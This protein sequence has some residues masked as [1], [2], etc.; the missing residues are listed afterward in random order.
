ME[1]FDLSTLK[2]EEKNI[3]TFNFDNFV[4]SKS[5][6]NAFV[7]CPKSFEYQYVKKE[8]ALPNK[9]MIKGSKIHSYLEQVNSNKICLEQIPP[10]YKIHILNY[11]DFLK[12][13]NLKLPVYSEQKYYTEFEGLK[14]SGIVDA[15]FVQDGKAIIVDYKTGKE[16]TSIM[17]YRFELQ[18]YSYLIE[19]NLKLDVVKYGILFTGNKLFLYENNDKSYID[20]VGQIQKVKKMVQ[21]KE[22]RQRNFDT[23]C[24]LCSFKKYC[25]NSNRNFDTV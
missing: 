5:S 12:V 20:I 19:K 3:Q 9:Y 6:M 17:D 13:Y 7:S 8:K 24:N 23:I 25:T 1:T 4:W 22:F 18:L 16:H 15:V 10:Q 14:F 21:D 2:T 11:L